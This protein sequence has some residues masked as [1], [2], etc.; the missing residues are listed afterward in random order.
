MDRND[1]VSALQRAGGSAHAC[2]IAVAGG[3]DFE[4]W[5]NLVPAKELVTTY[6]RRHQHVE[7]IG[8]DND[9]FETSVAALVSSTE[10]RLG[11]VSD[12]DANRH[13][14]LFLAAEADEVI[15]CLSVHHVYS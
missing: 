7:A 9:G 11:Q 4:V 1:L 13:Y 12:R 14:Q 5:D 2:S 15:G 6:G 3:A 8:L 10:V